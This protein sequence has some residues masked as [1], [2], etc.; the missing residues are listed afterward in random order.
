MK[1]KE[2]DVNPAGLAANNGYVHV[3]VPARVVVPFCVAFDVCYILATIGSTGYTYTGLKCLSCS[4]GLDTLSIVL[5]HDTYGCIADSRLYVACTEVGG[6]YWLTL[7]HDFRRRLA[8]SHGS[9]RWNQLD[10]KKP[11]DWNTHSLLLKCDPFVSVFST[12]KASIHF[13]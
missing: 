2:K 11:C 10:Y 8:E 6:K 5:N 4:G 12:W 3:K 13:A 9:L 1:G 7:R